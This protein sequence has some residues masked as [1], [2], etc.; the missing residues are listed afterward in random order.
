MNSFEA[1]TGLVLSE[2]LYGVQ[3]NLRDGAYGLED[4]GAVLPASVMVHGLEQGRPQ[5]I[6]Y[7]NDWGCER[8]G[9]SVNDLNSM[10]DD[11]YNRYFVQQELAPTFTGLSGYLAAGDTDSQFNF[12]QRVK[13]HGAD[14][15]T[16]CYTVCKLILLKEKSALKDRLVMLSSPVAGLDAIISRVNKVLDEDVYIKKH[17]RIFAA[18]T[19]REK[20]II[21]LL[22]NGKS[23]RDIAEDLFV[24]VHTVQTHRKNIIRK[25]GCHSFAELLKFALAFELI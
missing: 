25:T 5:G 13:F 11:Y 24:S 19:R 8:L 17:Y 21:R 6:V 14:T 16:W 3:K 1:K 22:A 9:T 23:S 12:F 10:G 7:M 20:E 15:Y 4:L 18:L 2:Q